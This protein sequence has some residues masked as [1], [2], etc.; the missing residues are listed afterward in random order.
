MKQ[1]L[2]F[3]FLKKIKQIGEKTQTELLEVKIRI[4]KIKNPIGRLNCMLNTND[5]RIDEL[6]TE[7]IIQ[8]PAQ[9]DKE[10]ENGKERPSY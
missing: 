8:N 4:T 7:E 10:I 9:K 1:P 6:G 2:Y 3:L 5:K